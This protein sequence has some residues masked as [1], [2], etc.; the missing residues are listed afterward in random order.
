VIPFTWTS[1][2][3]L[4]SVAVACTRAICH[5]LYLVFVFSVLTVDLQ[6]LTPLSR[7]CPECGATI[8]FWASAY[9]NPTFCPS[10]YLNKVVSAQR[11]SYF[12]IFCCITAAQWKLSQVSNLLGHC[13]LQT[14]LLMRPTGYRTQARK[15]LSLLHP[16]PY[17]HT[18]LTLFI[19]TL[20]PPPPFPD[21][22]IS[23]RFK[24]Q[25]YTLLLQ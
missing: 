20:P 18:T 9:R 12:R 17:S 23:L 5:S 6:S 4:L 22:L 3:F 19:V 21:L 7:E 24:Q 13:Q 2:S 14:S 8:Q 10:G 15:L 16:F 1:T 25:L 11:L